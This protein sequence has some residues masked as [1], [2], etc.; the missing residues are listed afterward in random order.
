MIFTIRLFTVA[1]LAIFH[2]SINVDANVQ[3]DTIAGIVGNDEC[4]LYGRPVVEN[5]QFILWL[6]AAAAAG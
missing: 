4:D 6:M 2:S 5:Y 1:L 3:D